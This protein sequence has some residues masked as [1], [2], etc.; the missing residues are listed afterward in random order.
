MIRW[1]ANLSML[2]N[3]VSFLERLD[4]AAKAGFGAVEFLWPSG[5]DLNALAAAKQ[6]AEVDVAL[7]G[8]DP[9]D[10]PKG[11]RGFPNDP[12]KIKWWRERADAAFDLA[13]KLGTR[14]MNVL[15]GNEI[16]GLTRAQMIDCLCENLTWAIPRADANDVTLVVEPLNRIESPRYILGRTAEA[17][18]VIESLHSPRVQL[19]FDVYHTQRTEGN[20]VRLLQEH[21]RQ[22]GHI[23]IADS[24]ARAQPGTGEINWRFVLSELEKLGYAGYVGLE[25]KPSPTTLASLAWLPHD[26][27]RACRTDDLSL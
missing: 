10:M 17:L 16:E 26:K 3:E 5:V 21:I 27:R 9:G 23:Q 2:F 14:R 22:I 7:F 11:D 8:I 4:A 6:Q 12:A 15:A 18:Q 20:L 13:K 19:Q 24:P 1:S 25:Y